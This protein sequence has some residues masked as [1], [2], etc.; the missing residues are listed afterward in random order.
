MIK[1]R[2]G[3]V[4]FG[5]ISAGATQGYGVASRVKT[6]RSTSIGG[7]WVGALRETLKVGRRG[8]HPLEILSTTKNQASALRWQ[9]A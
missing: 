9:Y 4:P 2:G 1:T 8:A 3:R 5:E 7:C 6:G